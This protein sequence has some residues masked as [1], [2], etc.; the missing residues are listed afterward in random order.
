MKIAVKTGKN[1][2]KTAIKKSNPDC[3]CNKFKSCKFDNGNADE[4][5]VSEIC[6]PDLESLSGF[7]HPLATIVTPR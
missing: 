7:Y 3:K 6:L 4:S 5:E 1:P 2:Q